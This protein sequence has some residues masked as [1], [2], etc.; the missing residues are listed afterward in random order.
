MKRFLILIGLVCAIVSIAKGQCSGCTP[1]QRAQQ[2][3]E[4]AAAREERA[5]EVS[6]HNQW[7]ERPKFYANNPRQ[8]RFKRIHAEAAFT[9]DTNR[10]VRQVTWVCTLIHP[11]THQTV[12]QYTLVTRKKIHP[13]KSA[14][15]K[16]PVVVPL[17]A[18]YP[19]RVVS[20][21]LLGQKLPAV[22]QAVQVNK[23]VE[24]KYA[25]GTVEHPQ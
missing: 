20:V 21:D 24:I 4:A 11:N 23:I 9:N 2:D 15:L 8:P 18:F 25:D 16:E 17:D 5:K 14:T 19:S 7:P 10:S 13:H 6:D 12:A 3:R 22:V 1:E